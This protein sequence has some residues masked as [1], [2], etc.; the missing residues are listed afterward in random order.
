MAVPC[1]N[2]PAALRCRRRNRRKNSGGGSIYQK[3][4]LI[5][6]E[7]SSRSFLCFQQNPLRRMQVVK[8]FYLRNIQLRR[9]G[10][11]GYQMCI[12]DSP[13]PLWAGWY[14]ESA[15]SVLNSHI[16]EGSGRSY[17]SRKNSFLPKKI[18]FPYLFNCCCQPSLF[19]LLSL[20][21][22]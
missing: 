14:K 16:P 12:R 6:S 20:I 4:G 18:F 1:H 8:S 5:R 19:L 7:N 2:N 15:Y 11:P 17:P 21:H 22:I 13:R 9:P 10:Q 3:K